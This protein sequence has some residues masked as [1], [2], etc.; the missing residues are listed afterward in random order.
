MKVSAKTDYACHALLELASRWPNAVPVQIGTIAE[1]QKI[2]AKFLTQI[3]VDLKQAVLVESIR[4]QKGGYVLARAPQEISLREVVA[5]F[6]KPSVPLRFKQGKTDVFV[7]IWQD[8]EE[9]TSKVMDKINFDDIL[10]NERNLNKV[11]MFTI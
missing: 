2:P 1:N 7:G 5:Y 10:K 8:L 3:L 6:E 4:G 11:H 9:Q